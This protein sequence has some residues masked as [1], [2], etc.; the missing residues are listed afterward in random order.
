MRFSDVLRR[1][2]RTPARPEYP[3]DFYDFTVGNNGA[4]T[5]KTSHEYV[6]GLGSPPAAV[7]VPSLNTK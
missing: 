5:T 7:L 4:Y 1:S 2:I 6:T 3:A